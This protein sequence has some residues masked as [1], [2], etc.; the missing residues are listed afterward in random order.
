MKNAASVRAKLLALSKSKNIAFQLIIFRFLHERF[1]YRLSK[2]AFN[3]NFVLKGGNLIY[4]LQY[5]V[6]RPTKDIDF[7]GLNIKNDRTHLESVFREILSIDVDDFVWFDCESIQSES[8]TENNKYNGIRIYINSGFDSIQQKIQIDIGF[9]DIVVPEIAQLYY[10]VL[11][12]VM[13]PI[14]LRAYSVETIIAEKLHAMVSLSFFNSRMKDFYDVYMLLSE[15]EIK[16]DQLHSAIS[17]TFENRK[18]SPGKIN[19]LEDEKYI[20]DRNLNTRWKLFLSNNN[21]TL[22]KDFDEIIK[23]INNKVF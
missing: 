22:N 14:L 2:S 17:T 21:I 6:G 11:I 10:P 1:L 4:A 9:G 20:Y 8:I 7:L 23:Y 12:D 15:S 3:Q 16:T 18:L 19:E 5:E 13:Q